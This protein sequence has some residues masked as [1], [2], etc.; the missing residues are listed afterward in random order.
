MWL[1]LEKSSWSTAPHDVICNRPPI[2]KR[3]SRSRIFC[4]LRFLTR[5]C[6]E[7]VFVFSKLCY[8]LKYTFK[9]VKLVMRELPCAM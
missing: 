3:F 4:G 1:D 9:S 6:K 7:V 2:L 5:N 8:V